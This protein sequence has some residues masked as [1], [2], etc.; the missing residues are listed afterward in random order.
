MRPFSIGISPYS[1]ALRPN[2]TDP[3]TCASIWLE[4]SSAVRRRVPLN[5]RCSRK[6]EAPA[7]TGDSS[8]EP[9]A[10][11]TP[12]DTLRMAGIASVMMRNPLGSTVR[13]TVPPSGS[14]DR[15]LVPMAQW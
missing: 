8:R 12:N 6:C 9:T 13:P 10:T 15:I 7:R 3:C 2:A 1:A 14:L 4:I 11:H 5:S